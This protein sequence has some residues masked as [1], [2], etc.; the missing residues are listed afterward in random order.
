MPAIS[1]TIGARLSV[2]FIVDSVE[3]EGVAAARV[4][5]AGRKIHVPTDILY[6]SAPF[7][8]TSRI[9]TGR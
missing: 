4:G 2:M 3:V 6:D 7:R 1:E 5:T 9:P 8:R